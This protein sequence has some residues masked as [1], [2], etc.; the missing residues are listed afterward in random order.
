MANTS[1]LIIKMISNHGPR[2]L[3]PLLIA[4]T[5]LRA[6]STKPDMKVSGG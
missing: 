5:P 3:E 4:G 1:L 2:F 6:L